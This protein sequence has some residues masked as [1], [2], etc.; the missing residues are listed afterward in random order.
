MILYANLY[1]V[2]LCFFLQVR[3]VE[4]T[5]LVFIDNAGRPNH[6]HDNLNFRLVEGIDEWVQTSIIQS[7]FKAR[8]NHGNRL[9]LPELWPKVLHYIGNWVPF[10]KHLSVQKLSWTL[11]QPHITQPWCVFSKFSEAS[12]RIFITLAMHCYYFFLNTSEMQYNC[13]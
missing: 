1:C 3:R 10:R 6:P 11:H 7:L 4:P 8:Q 13:W 12:G 2:C 9:S 5:R